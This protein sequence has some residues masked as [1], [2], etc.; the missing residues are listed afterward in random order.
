MSGSNPIL[1]KLKMD[2]AEMHLLLL[3][4]FNLVAC[5]RAS[6]HRSQTL[7]Q[8]ASDGMAITKICGLCSELL[9]SMSEVDLQPDGSNDWATMGQAQRV[10]GWAHRAL[11]RVRGSVDTCWW[12]A[13]TSRRS[14]S[15]LLL[16]FSISDTSNAD[17]ALRG[18]PARS[19]PPPAPAPSAR[20]A[21][22]SST[23][24]WPRSARVSV[25]ANTARRRREDR[26][27]L[28]ATE[29]RHKWGLKDGGR[30]NRIYTYHIHP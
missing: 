16:T 27:P 8:S 6:R 28:E 29:I 24:L 4:L 14:A 23:Y 19:P 2:H 25:P 5:A 7:A 22:C 11:C 12:A 9:E 18:H 1:A 30:R 20:S 26:N 17:V 15:P 21:R 3:Y 13:P 10:R